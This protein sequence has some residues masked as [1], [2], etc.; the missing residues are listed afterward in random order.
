MSRNDN[1]DQFDDLIHELKH[2]AERPSLPPTFKTELRSQLLNQYEQSRFTWGN[3]RQWTG[4]AVAL[5]VL[6]LIVFI[7][8]TN[9]S[10]QS[11]AAS[12]YM[13]TVDV[14]GRDEFIVY[15]QLRIELPVWTEFDPGWAEMTAESWQPFS[16][17]SSSILRSGSVSNSKGL[18]PTGLVFI[19]HYPHHHSHHS[20][21]SLHPYCQIHHWQ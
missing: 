21:C 20:P 14:P 12:A 2:E 7:S 15:D 13:G 5:G 17:S 18:S 3:L 19:P 6:A 8:W 9:L 10:R 4:T 1:L 16:R 11:G